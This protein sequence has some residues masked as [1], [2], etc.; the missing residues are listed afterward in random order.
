MIDKR[1]ALIARCAGPDDVAKVVAFARDHDLP[2]PSA[3][4]A[5]TAP[6]SGRATTAW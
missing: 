3:A 5:T 1:P 6:G 2:S 4:A